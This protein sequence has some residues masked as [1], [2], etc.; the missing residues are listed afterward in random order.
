[1]I[2]KLSSVYV[3][4]HS[5]FV[6]RCC[7]MAESL[8][9]LEIEFLHIRGGCSLV[10]VFFVLMLVGTC[11][12]ILSASLCVVRPTYRASHQTYTDD[13]FR[14][15]GQARSSFHL[16]V[17]ESVYI[18]TQ[19]PVLCKQKEFVFHLDSSSKQW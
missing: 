7:P 15:I 16:G 8:F 12:F 17:L 3:L 9:I 18:K 1:M 6:I 10:V 2:R 14:I 13:N 11:C 19:N 4:A 5:G